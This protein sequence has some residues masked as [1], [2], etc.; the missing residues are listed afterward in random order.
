[1]RSAFRR[2]Q[3]DAALPYLR[4][5]GVYALLAA[6]PGPTLAPNDAR[7]D[8]I[9]HEILVTT[10]GDS[11][12]GGQAAGT[13][14]TGNV[15]PLADALDRAA[16]D[17]R[18]NI[19][20]FSPTLFASAAPVVLK[21]P[22]PIIVEGRQSGHDML[23]ASDV[24]VTITLKSESRDAV[25]TVGHDGEF[26]VRHLVIS[27]GQR[28]G[29]LVKNNGRLNLDHV[30]VTGSK[31][32][33]AACFDTASLDLSQCR[34]TNNATHGVELHDESEA[35][36]SY[37]DLR[38]NGQ[39]GLAAFAKSRA[40]VADSYFDANGDWNTVLTGESSATFT[41]CLLR[42][43]RFAN[44]DISEAGTVEF[45]DCTLDEGHRF[46]IFATAQASVSLRKT[47]VSHSGS[48]GLELQDHS[49]VRIQESKVES[50]GD[51]GIILFGESTAD[52]YHVSLHANGAHGISMRDQGSARLIDCMFRNNRYSGVGCLD[53]ADG[54]RVLVSRCLFRENGMRPLYRGPVHIDPL[55][56]TPLRIEGTRVLCR[57][58]PHAEIELFLDRRGE[59]SR[60]LRSLQADARGL[61][62]VDCREVPAGMVMTASATFDGS[63]SEFNVIAGSSHGPLLSALLGRTGKFSDHGGRMDE[64]SLLRRWKPDTQLLF[65]LPEAPS[66]AIRRYARFFVDH[67]RD[68]TLGRAVATLHVGPLA[69]QPDQ[70]VVIPLKY[71]SARNTQLL[72]RG[73][74][75]Y[76]KWDA[77]GYFVNPMEIVL[78]LGAD[79]D[80]TCPRV[81]AH[82]MGHALG[83]CHARVGLLSRMQGSKAPPAGFI[84]DFSPTMTYYDV[85]AIH[86]LY[87]PRSTAGTTLRDLAERGMLPAERGRELV[88]IETPHEQPTFSPPAED[89]R[90]HQPQRIDRP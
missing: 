41:R 73:G 71:V 48:R 85:L 56:P 22:G 1:M 2:F 53:R 21:L 11:S 18:D 90:I 47:R 33:G 37:V 14:Q 46:G 45:N 20:R 35:T 83:L 28:R 42:R 66:D 17:P 84:N 15:L 60:Y 63:T 39:S 43:A 70:A 81:M 51:Y 8:A 29:I 57:A 49:R 6:Q 38:R 10:L 62:T 31:G 12:S 61:F 89:T 4:A 72:G 82:E 80:E 58:D 55:V 78:A 24:P 9:E 16:R 25:L 69:K 3:E 74:V 19:I 44:A 5:V 59:A 13:S 52:L 76:M 23:D 26:T 87:D 65:H 50:N 27:G 54:G 36:L 40:T 68:W 7:V 75:T 79:R 86:M 32:P 64:K 34:F 88:G 30:L 77:S 67:V